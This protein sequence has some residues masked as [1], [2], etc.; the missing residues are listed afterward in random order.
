M[1]GSIASG[2]TRISNFATSADCVSTIGCFR[3]L[4]VS[5]EQGNN[6]TLSI[7]GT[8]KQGLRPPTSVLDCGNSG[9]TMRL[10]SGILAGQRFKSTLTGDE[11]LQSRPMKRI[12]EPLSR[13]GATI[14]SRDGYAPLTISGG[15]LSGIEYAPPVASAQIKSCILLAGLF[16]DEK[17]IVIESTPT[18]DHTERMMREFGID[19]D[20]KKI[21]NGTEISVSASA[22]P[23][24]TELLIP[25]DMSSAAFFMV[26]AACL[27]DSRLTL[28]N[29]GLNP[30]R[31]AVV[32]VLRK[33][34]GNIEIN[35]EIEAAGEP[36]GDITVGGGIG[37]STADN[38]VGGSVI[39]NLIDE[40]P[41]LAIFGTQMK[42]GLEV[43]DAAEL[44]VKESDRIRSVVNNL[45][46]MN[47][48]VEEFDDGFRVGPSKLKGA[49]ID[50]YGD[51]RIAMAFGVAGLIARGETEIIGAECADVSFP[52]FFDVLEKAAN[53]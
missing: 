38:V 23:R 46:K 27:P 17:T 42:G 50:S 20:V 1:L 10:I 2:E 40:I 4:G 22:E 12:I 5:I 14:E 51:H 30:T 3:Q 32:D 34:G 8:G 31:S 6:G 36:V 44:R 43:R 9:T 15:N 19:V 26:A 25:G 7:Q 41:I 33:F 18:R 29:V 52:G 28:T 48:D 37:D 39:A 35:G 47:A 49:V 24:A 53:V 11:S 13:M 16:A 21:D 45:K